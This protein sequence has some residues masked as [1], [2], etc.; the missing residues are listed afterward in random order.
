M[1]TATSP[2]SWEP[3]GS[4]RTGAPPL[5]VAELLREELLFTRGIALCR[6]ATAMNVQLSL[7]ETY[8]DVMPVRQ[9]VW[10]HISG[11]GP[12]D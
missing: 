10:S 3:C 5:A 6:K 12:E 4:Q 2:D 9:K 8:A 1:P 7:E 11:F